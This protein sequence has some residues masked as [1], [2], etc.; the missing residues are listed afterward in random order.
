MKGTVSV[1]LNAGS[2]NASV[3][4]T[5]SIDD[6]E[7]TEIS[8]A[9]NPI[10]I[11]GGLPD[12]DSFDI[13][14]TSLN[15]GGWDFNGLTS[16]IT[17]RA[18]DRFNNDAPD[19]TQVA[20]VTDGGKITGTCALSNGACSVTW[21]SQ[22]PL[23]GDADADNICDA[24]A[25]VEC[26]FVHI[27]A[28]TVGE[29]SF[30]DTNGNGQ[31]DIGEPIQLDL[32]EAFNDSNENGSWDSGE[33]FSDFNENGDFDTKS[34]AFFQGSNCSDTASAAGHCEDLVDVRD[35]LRLCMSTDETV[36]RVFNSA[37]VETP[38]LSLS[39]TAGS[40]EA[41]VFFPQL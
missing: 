4:I 35:S 30:T 7:G 10:S 14:A 23:P 37:E 40:D 2:V 26:G 13:S 24:G 5:A 33:F 19:G 27:L 20:F 1:T 15:P 3:T 28:R 34:D 22:K 9:S 25:S 36:T 18:G 12:Q 41:A 6:G 39:V 31:F 32:D 11:V 21:T 29:E 17:V 38:G 8:T 16:T